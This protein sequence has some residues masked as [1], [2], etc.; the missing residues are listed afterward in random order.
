MRNVT[1]ASRDSPSTGLSLAAYAAFAAFG[2][3]WGTWGATLPSIRAQAGLSD[4]Q[5]GFSLLF[6]GA[7]ALP[8]MLMTGRALDRFGNRV[9]A[10]LLALLGVTGI[11]M[12][13][14]AH[15]PAAIIVGMLLVGATSGAADVAI[16]TL[17]GHA[18][19]QSSRAVLSRAHGVFSLAVV[20]SSLATGGLLT[21]GIGLPVTFALVA[22]ALAGLAAIVHAKARPERTLPRPADAPARADLR[23]P[24]LPLILLG[25]VGALAYAT[26]NAHQSWGAVLITDAFDASPLVAS[27]APATFAAAATVARFAL[28]PLTR[29][30]PIPLLIAGG[31]VATAGSVILAGAPSA[32]VGLIGLAVAAAGVATLYPTLLSHNLRNIA[33]GSRG[34]ATSSIATT[35]YL[36]YLLG[37]AYVGLLA[38]LADLRFAIL[39]VGFLA[40]AF[41]LVAAPASHAAGRRLRGG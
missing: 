40:L 35:A 6:V 26:E 30:H 20:A 23:L 28:A 2:I 37:P 29:S 36:G 17:A 3:F 31:A 39:A 24:A 27:L 25:A 8:T 7:G 10:V 13:L 5:L 18:E 16:N 38:D 9:T 4:G 11:L 15:G 22:V 41:T 33:P 1:H 19:Q 14:V 12:A 21:L 32:P 34:R